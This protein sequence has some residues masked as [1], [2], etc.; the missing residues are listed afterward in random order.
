MSTN[1]PTDRYARQVRNEV[2]MALLDVRRFLGLAIESLEYPN[3]ITESVFSPFEDKIDTGTLQSVW[4][5]VDERIN[6][7]ATEITK[8]ELEKVE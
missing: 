6:L 7:L 2:Y 4:K 3:G 5:E 1:N 8:P